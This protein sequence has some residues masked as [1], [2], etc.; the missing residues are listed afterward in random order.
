M[1]N[2][3]KI[4]R[5]WEV[6]NYI[7]MIPS[8]AYCDQTSV[9]EPLILKDE[10]LYIKNQSKGFVTEKKLRSSFFDSMDS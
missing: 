2:E 7:R 4:C 1:L 10:D 3:N 8:A 9:Y 6:L 5:Q